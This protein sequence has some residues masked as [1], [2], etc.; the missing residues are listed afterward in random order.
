MKHPVG[1]VVPIGSGGGPSSRLSNVR[2]ILHDS[3]SGAGRLGEALKVLDQS[4]AGSVAGY[5]KF[6]GD[7]ELLVFNHLNEPRDE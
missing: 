5:K 2:D 6:R 7:L 4:D 3:L 1:L